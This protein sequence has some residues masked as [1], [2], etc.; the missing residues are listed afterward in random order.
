[1]VTQVVKLVFRDKDKETEKKDKTSNFIG[2]GLISKVNRKTIGGLK[3]ML[4]KKR[5]HD[6]DD[7]DDYDEDEDYDHF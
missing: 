1:M 4:K 7:D 2:S 3:E 5:D 6:D